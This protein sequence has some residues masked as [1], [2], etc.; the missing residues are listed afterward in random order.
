MCAADFNISRLESFHLSVYS[1]SSAL[2]HFS[3]NMF[4]QK[5]STD[6]FTAEIDRED[7]SVRYPGVTDLHHV[8]QKDGGLGKTDFKKC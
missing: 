1:Y 6:T 3:Q 8:M 2:A 4:S 5:A 7:S